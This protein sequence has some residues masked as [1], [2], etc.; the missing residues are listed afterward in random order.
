MITGGAIVS[1]L[2]KEHP[3]DYDV[4]FTNKETTKVVAE[5]YVRKFKETHPDVSMKVLD[6]A[7]EEDKIGFTLYKEVIKYC[8][9][10]E[11]ETKGRENSKFYY[12][13]DKLMNSVNNAGWEEKR[14]SQIDLI[15]KYQYDITDNYEEFLSYF[16]Y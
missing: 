5:Y 4:Y 6:G 3:K 12:F 16:F 13:L 7:I 9:S 2:Q 11:K 15:R 10:L 1:L 14:S 8:E